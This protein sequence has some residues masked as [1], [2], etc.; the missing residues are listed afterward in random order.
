MAALGTLAQLCD[1]CVGICPCETGPSCLL[2]F[3]HIPPAP[4]HGYWEGKG[5]AVS[6]PSNPHRLHHPLEK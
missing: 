1:Q 4:F 3:F 6:Q 2:V 5:Q